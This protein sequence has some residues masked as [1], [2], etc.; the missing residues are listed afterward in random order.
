MLRRL[1]VENYVLIDKLEMELDPR[2]NIITGEI[3]AFYLS[4]LNFPLWSDVNLII[5]SLIILC[6]QD[7]DKS[8]VVFYHLAANAHQRAVLVTRPRYFL[9][10]PAAHQ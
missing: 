2:L 7:A 1:S 5:F 6:L 9:R 10:C 4:C 3:N 8:I